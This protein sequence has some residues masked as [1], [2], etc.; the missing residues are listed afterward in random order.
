MAGYTKLF[1]SIVHSTIWRE[2]NHVRLVWITMLAMADKD[3]VVEASI[4][5]LADAARVTLEECCEAL[6]RLMSPDEFSRSKEFEGRRIGPV[7]GGWVLLNY[8]RYRDKLNREEQRIKA[9]QRQREYRERKKVDVTP[10]VTENHNALCSVMPALWPS[11][12]SESESDPESDTKEK[13]KKKEKSAYSAS[14]LS[15]WA[16]YPKKKEKDAAWRAWQKAVK[17]A[18]PKTIIDAVE[19]H[20]SSTEWQSGYIKYPATWLNKGCWD[21]EIAPQS[22]N[23]PALPLGT[24]SGQTSTTARLRRLEHRIIGDQE[25]DPYEIRDLSAVVSADALSYSK[26]VYDWLKTCERVGALE[27]DGLKVDPF[28]GEPTRPST[29]KKWQPPQQGQLDEIVEGLMGE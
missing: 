12:Q 17:K 29:L 11:L 26:R 21:D 25:I 24:N 10:F 3:G 2:E 5:G 13:R 6:E 15:F 20:K 4:P 19:K 28:W 14:F 22:T 8:H 18:E 1:S 23:N 16:A 7:E 27:M 9:A